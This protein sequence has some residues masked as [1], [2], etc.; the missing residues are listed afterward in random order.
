[1]SEETCGEIEDRLDLLAAGECD[2]EEQRIV[3]AH[4]AQCE[5]CAAR[6]AESRRLAGLLNLHFK[7]GAPARLHERI[8]QESHRLRRRQ[9]IL[10]WVRLGAAI[11]AVLVLCIGLILVLPKRAADIPLLD[12]AL[13]V[14][15]NGLERHHPPIAPGS[16]HVATAKGQVLELEA[17]DRHM[18]AEFRQRLTKDSAEGHAPVPELALPLELKLRNQTTHAVVAELGGPGSE[19]KIDV[20]GDAV[21]RVPLSRTERPPLTDSRTIRLEPGEEY[22]LP[23]DRLIA[24]SAEKVEYIYLTEPGEYTLQVTLRL[25]VAGK[26]MSVVSEPVRVR[27][28]GGK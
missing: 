24:G 15:S 4:L 16:D 1:M 11:A 27:L 7:S 28:S 17:P 19:V 18:G 2:A 21:V 9:V 5:R 20:E 14:Q 6:F 13:A 12:L 23:V 22:L 25:S 26:P 10:P 3:E 8:E